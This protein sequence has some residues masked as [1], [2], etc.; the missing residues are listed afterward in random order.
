MTIVRELESGDIAYE[1]IRRKYGIKGSSTV[2]KWARKYGKGDLGKIIRVEIPKEVNERQQMKLRIKALEKALADA[3]IDLA[4]ERATIKAA[5]Q[6]AG[7]E[8]VEEFK[9]KARGK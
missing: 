3:H 2:Q 6:R 4:I 5:C 9:K 1:A 7:I 8:N